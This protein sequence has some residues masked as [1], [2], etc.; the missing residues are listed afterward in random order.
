MTKGAPAQVAFPVVAPRAVVVWGMSRLLLAA[1]PLAAGA[2]FGSMSPP[3]LA[4]VLLT[5]LL[6]LVDVRMRGERI[7][8][9]NLGVTPAVLFALYAAPAVPAE[10]LLA[11]GLALR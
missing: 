9:A 11:F 2:P 10:L 6:G 8:W 5:G 7:L 3:P 1:M 4:V